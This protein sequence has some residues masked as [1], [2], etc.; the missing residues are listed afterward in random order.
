ML[1]NKQIFKVGVSPQIDAKHMQ[2]DYSVQVASTIDLRFLAKL[3][4]CQPGSL[5]KMSENYLGEILDKDGARTSNWE[6]SQLS[7]EQINYAADDGFASIELFK[8]F[9]ELIAGERRFD[10]ETDQ[11]KYVIRNH[12]AEL[13]DKYYN[14]A[15]NS[16]ASFVRFQ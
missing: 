7:E 8:Y 1:R 15:P 13:L 9:A 6:T 14:H 2:T 5:A 10:N 4:G 16:T 3:A 11:L 12:C